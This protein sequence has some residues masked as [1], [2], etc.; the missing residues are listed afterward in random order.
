MASLLNSTF[1]LIFVVASLICSIRCQ[2][3]NQTQTTTSNTTQATEDSTTTTTTTTT[4]PK[5]LMETTNAFNGSSTAGSHFGSN[6]SSTEFTV[7]TLNSNSTS[8]TTGI[9]NGTETPGIKI[10]TTSELPE[11]RPKTNGSSN[12]TYNEPLNEVIPG[13]SLN[14]WLR[15][16]QV[17]LLVIGI[18]VTMVAVWV[19]CRNCV[20][21]IESDRNNERLRE[22]SLRSHSSASSSETS[23]VAIAIDVGL[24]LQ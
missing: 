12:D 5:I 13:P 8:N 4:S 19:D 16:V 7:S 24:P 20:D 23:V 9:S 11:H 2:T 1:T 3:A 15:V 21:N 6:I 17:S 22:A 18:T 14:W 10:W